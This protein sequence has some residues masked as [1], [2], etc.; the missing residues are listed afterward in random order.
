MILPGFTVREGNLVESIRRH[1]APRKAAA[2]P[3][4]LD[5]AAPMLGDA[6]DCLH[7]AISILRYPAAVLGHVIREGEG[8]DA[9]LV[10][11][12][13][14]LPERVGLPLVTT[15]RYRLR[16]VLAQHRPP[17]LEDRLAVPVQSCPAPFRSIFSLVGSCSLE[18]LL[19]AEWS[20]S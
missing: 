5:D 8:P 4:R 13:I 6:L 18:R 15:G 19:A 14:P 2:V 9:L 12:R 10:I 17:A 20:Q 11:L 7:R 1:D 16:M 3:Q